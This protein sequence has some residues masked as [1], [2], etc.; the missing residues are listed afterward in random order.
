[1]PAPRPLPELYEVVRLVP[2]GRVVTYGDLATLFDIG[3]RTAGRHMAYNPHTD[4]P[5]WRVVNAS[6]RLPKTLSA[7]ALTQWRTEG[8]PLNRTGSGVAIR[9]A[10]ADLPALAEVLERALGPLPGLQQ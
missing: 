1:M 10:H 6:G 3:A 4:L 8:T 2:P 9:L 7:H 5:W